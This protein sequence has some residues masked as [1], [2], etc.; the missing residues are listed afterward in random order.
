MSKFSCIALQNEEHIQDLLI[1]FQ[2]TGKCMWCVWFYWL[3]FSKT[4]EHVCGLFG[5]CGVGDFSGISSG[6]NYEK[7]SKTT[8]TKQTTYISLCFENANQ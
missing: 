4:R 6:P 3:A 5:V 7:V 8:K 1:T 2:K